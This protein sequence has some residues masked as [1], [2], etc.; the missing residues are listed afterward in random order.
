MISHPPKLCEA[1]EM[2]AGEGRFWANIGGRQKRGAR[3]A[4][5]RSLAGKQHAV[6]NDNRYWRG[7]K[8]KGK[9]KGVTSQ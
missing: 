6:V 4:G 5:W 8:L 2:P 7:G 3:S 9:L 1:W